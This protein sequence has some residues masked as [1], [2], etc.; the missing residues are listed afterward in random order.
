M[1]IVDVHTDRVVNSFEE[2]AELVQPFR[3]DGE[4]IFRGVRESTYQLIPKLGRPGSREVNR[5]RVNFA[6][7]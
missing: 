1:S 4:W 5:V 7:N 6:E 2:L 3:K